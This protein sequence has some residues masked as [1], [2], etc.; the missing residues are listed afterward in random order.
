MTSFQVVNM[1][2]RR[3]RGKRDKRRGA[4]AAASLPFASEEFVGE[5]AEECASQ[6]LFRHNRRSRVGRLLAG[7][8]ID[9][10][11]AAAAA[12]GN[13]DHD[14]DHDAAIAKYLPVDFERTWKVSKKDGRRDGWQQQQ[15]PFGRQ[16]GPHQRGGHG[17][18]PMA[19]GEQQQQQQRRR[20]QSVPTPAPSP[21]PTHGPTKQPI[22]TP[23]P[24]PSPVPTSV[25]TPDPPTQIPSPVPTSVPTRPIPDP[26]HEFDFRG[27]T[28]GQSIPDTYAPSTISATAKKGAKC[29]ANGIQL[30]A[31]RKQYVE[32]TPWE[33]GSDEFSV[34]I[35]AKVSE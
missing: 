5:D 14:Y 31:K 23:T 19:R 30:D 34:E 26:D 28:D 25:P 12:E 29:T 15:Q 21:V 20:L 4:T 16:R 8:Q 35:L 11:L 7:R 13:F 6:A 10:A 17:H 27:C 9:E 33:F 18:G 24:K 1:F 22:P 2:N 3:R 32:A